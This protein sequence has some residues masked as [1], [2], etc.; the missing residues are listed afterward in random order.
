MRIVRDADELADAVA[1][2]QREAASAFGDGTVFL[3][4]YVDAPRHIEIQIFGDAH[5]NVVHLFERECSI[6]R[7]H[8]KIIEEAPSP[9]VTHELRPRWATP[10]SPRRSAIGY[11][12]AGTVEFVLDARRRRSTSSR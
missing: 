9:V 8:Q 1:S 7:R 12:G 2:A 5:G 4:R 3:E 6:Q 11:V 10:R